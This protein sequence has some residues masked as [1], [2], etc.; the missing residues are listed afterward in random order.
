MTELVTFDPQ[1]SLFTVNKDGLPTCVI[2]QSFC[3]LREE[4]AST[5]LSH[6]KQVRFIDRLGLKRLLSSSLSF[7]FAEN[8]TSRLC[9]VSVSPLLF[10]G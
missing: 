10:M 1:F 9:V 5:K 6:M 2:L 4:N 7:V 8:V 3:V